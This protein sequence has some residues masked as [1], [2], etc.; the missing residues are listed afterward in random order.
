MP[1]IAVSVNRLNALLTQEFS[2]DDLVDALE[3]MG[4]DVEDTAELGIYECPTCNTPNDKLMGE[5]PPKRCDFC[6]FESQEEFKQVS[7][8]KVIR[9]DL[10]AARPDL[11]DIGGLSRAL[12]GY[13]GLEQGLNLFSPG[14]SNIEV[15][16][17]AVMSE[18]DTY[19]PF[20]VCAVVRMPPLDHNSLRDIMK[21]QESLHWGIGRDRKLAS[22]GVYDL[23]TIQPPIIYS[24]V[25]PVEF[26]FCPLGMPGTQMSPKKILEE[27]PKGMAYAH[28]M[29]KYKRYPIL[30]DV[31]G[32]VLSMPP[33]INSEETRL[34]VGSTSL[35]IDITGI[36]RDA[37]VKSLDTLVSSLA[38]L[39]GI[40]ETVQM[41]YT[42]KSLLTPDLNPG[43]IDIKYEEAKK[44]LGIDFTTDEFIFYLKKCAW[45]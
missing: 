30:K 9:L 37:V 20:I 23:D 36:T 25:D 34:K 13:L 8:D 12:K 15:N 33:I 11:F 45:M 14:K 28:L 2:R 16:I 7:V 26:T 40:I 42:D 22:I 24:C 4:C 35:F 39:G 43:T 10:L 38:E 29:D 17:D 32:Q 1:I 44:W 41:N 27:H 19:R 31:N 18:K 5:T 3:Q 6:G 21:L